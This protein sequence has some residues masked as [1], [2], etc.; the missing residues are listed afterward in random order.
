MGEDGSTLTLEGGCLLSF[1]PE[2]GID[3]EKARTF[4][5]FRKIQQTSI[6]TVRETSWIRSPIDNFVL[7]QLESKGL[8]PAPPA[9]KHAWL[10]RVTF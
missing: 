5:A 9:D 1:G 10:R 7:A 8:K 6:P 4:W 2:A 3:F